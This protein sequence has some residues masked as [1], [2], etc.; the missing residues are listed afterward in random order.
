[1]QNL[2]KFH[3]ELLRDIKFLLQR[4]VIYYNKKRLEGPRLQEKDK[5]YLLRRNIKTTRPSD[6]LDHRKFRS[7]T[8]KRNIKDTSFKL[9]LS[10][11]IKIH[12]IFYISLLESASLDIPE[13][14]PLEIY[15]DI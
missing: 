11:I 15:L 13:R 7:F 4:S 2:K 8:I 1:M 9:K 6:K 5:I 12:P 3:K 10:P 14:P